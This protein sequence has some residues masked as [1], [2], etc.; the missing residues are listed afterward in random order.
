MG[1]SSVMAGRSVACGA[2]AASC[3]GLV[4]ATRR[5]TRRTSLGAFASMDR[6]AKRQRDLE[7]PEVKFVAADAQIFN[8]VSDDCRAVRRPDATKTL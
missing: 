8:D 3:A 4:Q 6:R 1:W 2:D 7:F 5:H